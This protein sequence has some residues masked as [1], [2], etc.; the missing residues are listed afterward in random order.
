MSNRPRC[1]SGRLE[2]CLLHG[3][4]SWTAIPD[5]LRKAGLQVERH[6]D[7]FPANCSDETWLRGIADKGWIA[8]THD[9]RIR[10]KPNELAAVIAH[11]I[12]L[13]VVV[14][15]APYADLARAFVATAPL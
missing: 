9:A 10:Y 7:Y 13:L 5:I 15:Q 14:G 4:R 2:H 8:V 12:F 3:S 1:T 11:R 6:A